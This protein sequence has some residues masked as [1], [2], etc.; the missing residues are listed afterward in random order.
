MRDRT[1]TSGVGKGRAGVEPAVLDQLTGRFASELHEP[2]HVVVRE[3]EVA[4]KFYVIVRGRV[5]VSS[6]TAA[7]PIVLEEGDS[8]YYSAKRPHKYKNIGDGPARA[9]HIRSPGN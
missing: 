2:G 6:T 8:A 9:F 1:A 3:G 4:D 7:E 5:E